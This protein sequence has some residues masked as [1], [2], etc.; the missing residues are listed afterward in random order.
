MRRPAFRAGERA[1][2][3]SVQMPRN[4]RT[5]YGNHNLVRN[6]FIR[7]QIKGR[8]ELDFEKLQAQDISDS[9]IKVQLGDKTIEQLFKIQV[10]DPT[11]LE[12]LDEYNARKGAGET[13]EQLEKTPPLGR[14]Q[15]QISKTKNFAQQG[16]SVN[17]KVEMLTAAVL[18]GNTETKEQMAEITASVARVLG[19]NVS[20]QQLTHSNMRSLQ[21]IIRHLNLP[22]NYRSAGFLHQLFDLDQYRNEQGLVNLYLLSNVP[23]D[24]TLNNP[25]VKYNNQGDITSR[26]PL[27]G[28]VNALQ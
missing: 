4:K 24:R 21:E 28:I 27:T 3:Q 22:K 9:G 13:D 7:P 5:G 17:D 15:R 11:D 20:L 18:Q 8:E 23:A 6:N 1:N 14:P 26:T 16:E 12:W 10:A 2:V 25:L 19:S